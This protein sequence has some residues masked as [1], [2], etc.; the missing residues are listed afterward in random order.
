MSHFDKLQNE[1]LIRIVSVF[2][3]K[4]SNWNFERQIQI[5]GMAVL[6]DFQKKGIGENLF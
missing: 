2:E 5:R 4:H 1:N 3:N 6:P